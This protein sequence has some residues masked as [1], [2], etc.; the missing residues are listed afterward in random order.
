M[1]VETIVTD[2]KN[3]IESLKPYIDRDVP[4]TTKS[5][6]LGESVDLIANLVELISGFREDLAPQLGAEHTVNVLLSWRGDIH[7]ALRANNLYLSMHAHEDGIWAYL[8]DGATGISIGHLVLM[9][10]RP[11]IPYFE[12]TELTYL[13]TFH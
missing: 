3:V 12:K 7:D 6:V 2:F 4:P 5:E 8:R 1:T 13:S 9:D 10:A 11:Y